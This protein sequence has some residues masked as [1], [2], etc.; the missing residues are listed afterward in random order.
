VDSYVFTQGYSKGNKVSRAVFHGAADIFTLGLWEI[1]GTPVEIIADGH[2]MK[3]E[4]FYDHKEKVQTVVYLRGH[5][6]S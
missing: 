1:V 2:E 5:P 4:V 3:I 6:E